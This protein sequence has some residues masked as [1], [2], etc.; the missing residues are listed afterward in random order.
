VDWN[1]DG[2]PDVVSGDRYGNFNLFLRQ[3]GGELIAHY[4]MRTL[5]GE[6]I[7]V[8]Y[9]SQPAMADW[10]RDGKKDLLLGSE[11]GNIRLYLNQTTDTWPG[12]QDYSLIQCNGVPISLYRVN[13]YVFDLD[14]DGKQDLVCGANDG[15]VHFFPNVG[16]DTNPTFMREETLKADNGLPIAP[17]SLPYGSRLGFGDWNNDGWPDFLISGYDGFIELWLG[18][19]LTGVGAARRALD[20][21][22]VTLSCEPNPARSPVTFEYSL[23]RAANVKLELFDAGGRKRACLASGRS[24]AGTYNK[25]W[26][27]HCP[28]GIYLCRLTADGQVLTRQ[29]TKLA[30]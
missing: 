2:L 26:N 22:R 24:P 28:A 25:V 10:N 29:V 3:S 1:S 18:G 13:P 30:N 17:D 27:A 12:F 4:C 20:A 21:G 8:A 19:P 23:P 15:Y 11:A 7:N 5:I 14:G 6:S 16:S 9:S